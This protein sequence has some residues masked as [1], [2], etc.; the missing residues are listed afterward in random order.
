MSDELTSGWII[1]GFQYVA[2]LWI[3]VVGV[4]LNGLMRSLYQPEPDP[5]RPPGPIDS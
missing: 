3:W 4:L 1:T 5:V 2:L